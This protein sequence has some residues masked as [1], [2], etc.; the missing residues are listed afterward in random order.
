MKTALLVLVAIGLC[1]IGLGRG[2]SAAEP[3]LRFGPQGEDDRLAGLW[4]T[5][6]GEQSAAVLHVGPLMESVHGNLRSWN[7]V[8]HLPGT[9]EPLSCVPGIAH[10][11]DAAPI[12]MR[13][14][15]FEVELRPLEGLTWGEV[16]SD[17]QLVGVTNGLF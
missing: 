17:A 10:A 7:L 16:Y 8:V 5:F 6:M 3:E 2:T 11:E 15:L 12:L 9:P 14:E 4:W 13:G 1:W